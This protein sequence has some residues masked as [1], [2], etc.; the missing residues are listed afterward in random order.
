MRI[1]TDLMA[2]GHQFYVVFPFIIDIHWCFD[3]QK[4]TKVVMKQSTSG[5]RTKN[6]VISI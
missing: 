3:F 6:L 2:S 4:Y 5:L 1:Q